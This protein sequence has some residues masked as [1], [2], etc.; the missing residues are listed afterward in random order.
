[1]CE[2]LELTNPTV[3]LEVLDE[4]ERS[5]FFLGRQGNVI[6]ESGL[7]SLILRSRLPNHPRPGQGDEGKGP[8]GRTATI[9]GQGYPGAGA[10]LGTV[11][12]LA[13]R[14]RTCVMFWSW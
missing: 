7:Y 1:M 13:K 14:R 12:V 5:K 3:A 10:T 11:P 6:S 8:R 9:G 4:D 2:V